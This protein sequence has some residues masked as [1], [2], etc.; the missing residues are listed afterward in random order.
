[1]RGGG[2]RLVFT[3]LEFNGGLSN[4]IILLSTMVLKILI[5]MFD[6]ISISELGC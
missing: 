4:L 1:M 6:K 5:S 2:G 3:F